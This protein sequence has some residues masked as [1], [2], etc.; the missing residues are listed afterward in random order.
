MEGI[1]VE[2]FEHVAGRED[3]EIIVVDETIRVR[4]LLAVED[5]EGQIWLED[6]DEEINLE[7]TLLEAG[8][9]HQHHVQRSHCR[10]ISVDV[11]FADERFHRDFAPS[12]T[13]KRVREWAV[14]PD[15][16]R[17]S[18]DQ[19]VEHV[20]ATPGADHF[21]DGNVHVGS[22]VVGKS[23]S[24]IVDLLPRNRFEG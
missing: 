23:C 2:L 19:A 14:G 4:E 12:T 6:V 18:P 16:A 1:I 21:L 24:V 3:P 9:G 5:P 11:R 15:A 20:L 17:L 8:I 10:V 7:L 13:I 22:L